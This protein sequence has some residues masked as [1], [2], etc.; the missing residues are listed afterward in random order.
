MLEPF[1]QEKRSMECPK[2]RGNMEE[3]FIKDESQSA[4]YTSK[5]VEGPPEKSAW[6]G[7]KIRGKKVLPVATYRCAACG[8]LESFAK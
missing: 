2:C 5:W 1:A 7:T 6:T 8:Y 3:G 4:V